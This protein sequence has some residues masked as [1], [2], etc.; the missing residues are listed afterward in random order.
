MKL[1]SRFIE[2]L[3]SP[4]VAA[5]MKAGGNTAFL[6]VGALEMHGPHMPNGTDI[7][8]ARG[9]AQRLA[10]ECNGLVFPD[11]TYSWA[12]ATEGFA[13]TIS[14]PP[15]LVMKTV[16]WILVKMHAQGFRRLVVVSIHGGNNAQLTLCVR[17]IYETHG[18]VAQYLNPWVPATPEAAKLFAGKWEPGMEASLTLAALEILGRRDL[19]SEKEMAY[20][21]PPPPLAAQHM[22]FQGATG[23]YYQD[24]RHHAAPNRFTSRQRA[25]GFIELQVKAFKSG[26]LNLDK[27]ARLAPRQKNQGWFRDVTV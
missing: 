8:I 26:I 9:V 2:E 25:R 27:Y 19:Y 22:K 1:R 15:E 4:E 10:E 13:G 11:L 18:I 21:D 24:L 7:I 16:T 5:W 3:T 14:I 20:D 17:R 6:P 12:G 23:F